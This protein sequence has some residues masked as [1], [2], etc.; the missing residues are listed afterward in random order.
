M[1][2]FPVCCLPA[3][4]HG[5]AWPVACGMAWPVACVV[6]CGMA[7]PVACVVACVACGLRWPIMPPHI[8]AP[9]TLSDVA[10]WAQKKPSQFPGR[11]FCRLCYRA[12][13]YRLAVGDSIAPFNRHASRSSVSILPRK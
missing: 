2:R 12:L 10:Q 13:V 4:L 9:I 8:V 11:A 6:A 7:W 3:C 1:G 5:M